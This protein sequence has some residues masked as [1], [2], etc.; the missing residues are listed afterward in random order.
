MS[1][2]TDYMLPEF[3]QCLWG[4]AIQIHTAIRAMHQFHEENKR[5]PETKDN[6]VI[7][8]I[9]GKLA[10]A[11][12]VEDLNMDTVKAVCAYSQASI[13]P[14]C[15]F[16]GGIVAQEVVKATGKYT[17]LKQWMHYDIAECVPA[18]GNR[19]LMNCRYDDYIRVFG[20]EVQEKMGAVRTFMV[21][22]GALGCELIKAFALM[23]LG[24]GKDGHI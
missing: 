17:P 9:A 16:F 19:E 15:A 11:A 10:A 4:R 22:A 21:G 23:G 6:E 3:N 18:E 7:C 13:S 14:L 20:R 24:C 1:V 12:E 2:A 5:Y 8:E